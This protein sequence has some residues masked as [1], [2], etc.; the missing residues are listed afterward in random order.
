MDGLSVKSGVM[1]EVVMLEMLAW[2]RLVSFHILFGHLFKISL[3]K[4][5]SE[6]SPVALAMCSKAENAT[7][8]L[9]RLHYSDKTACGVAF[10]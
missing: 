4:M 8:H 1:E 5:S 10:L 7:A 2:L 3:M 9:S 6:K